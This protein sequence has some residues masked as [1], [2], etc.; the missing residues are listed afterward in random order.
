M[1]TLSAK[2]VD[3]KRYKKTTREKSSKQKEARRQE[4]KKQE[5]IRKRINENRINK[6][7]N[8]IED[9]SYIKLNSYS[10]NIN[11]DKY[12][13][14]N[15][16]NKKIYNNNKK[17]NKISKISSNIGIKVVKIV[18]L[19]V[20]VVGISILSKNIVNKYNNQAMVTTVELDTGEIVSLMQDSAMVVGMANLDSNELNKTQNIVLNEIYNLCNL[21]LVEFDNKYNIEY[22]VAEKIE[23][24]SNKEY[25][26]TLNNKYDVNID[27]IKKSIENIKNNGN[28]NIYYN[29]I[30]KIS[31]VTSTDKNVIKMTLT[32]DL[33]YF[34][35]SLDFPILK[36]KN[37][38]EE[39]KLLSNLENE[40][41][42]SR[43]NSNSTVKDI[44]FKNYTDTDNLIEEF[45]NKKIDIFTASSDS[46]MSL[47][48]K[49]DYSVKK[50]RDGQTLFLLGNNNSMLYSMKEVRKAILYLIN[51]DE[52]IENVNNNFLEKI[53]IPYIYSDIKYKYDV[54]GAQ[55]ALQSQ[56]WQ[57]KDGIY[58]KVIDKKEVSLELTI[59][60]NKKD[61]KKIKVA[62]MIKQM[63]EQN[64]IKVNIKALEN[65]EF[66]NA[67]NKK[68]YD[69]LLADVYI[70]NIPDITFIEN[71]LNV[72]ENIASAINI[73]K[74]SSIDELPKN[75]LSLQEI[76]SN[77][78]AC[79][80]IYAINTNVVYQTNITG[81]IDPKYMNIFNDFE[82]VGKIQSVGK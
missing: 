42:F 38:E 62:E 70:N 24:I 47:I 25:L 55:N 41:R 75:I 46:I 9:Y 61:T 3:P 66:E 45:R 34:I 17:V 28:K 11:L 81:I 63:L 80:G 73:T 14:K 54:Y 79:I 32:E 23:K 51:R 52:I 48:G 31:D 49:H 57:R 43:N 1:I 20:L 21:H 4:L 82:K 10:D 58:K 64:G 74:N 37:K 60:V 76:L 2:I 7:Q 18:C 71:Y 15:V 19:V 44:I 8:K 39:Y 16:N 72:S 59:L 56:G 67:L 78:V 53:D 65:N 50:Y 22:K 35:Y 69:L 77:E 12:E 29:N 13:D 33:P 5:K 68:E 27:D 36:E 6:K 40:I 26:I 30:I